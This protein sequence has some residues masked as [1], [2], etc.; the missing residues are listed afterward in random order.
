MFFVTL[1]NNGYRDITENLILSTYSIS[2]EWSQQFH[3][4]CLDEESF[5]YFTEKY[6]KNPVSKLYNHDSDQIKEWVKYYPMQSTNTVGKQSWSNFTFYK[7]ILI[8]EELKK[9]HNIV[10][11]DGDIVILRNFIQYI[12]QMIDMVPSAELIIQNDNQTVN[13]Q[14]MCTGFFWMKSNQN[15]ITATDYSKIN[16]DTFAN[17]QQYMRSKANVIKHLYLDLD[18]FPNGKYFRT[19]CNRNNFLPK[20]PYLIHFNYDVHK[21]KITRMKKYN[22]WFHDRDNLIMTVAEWQTYISSTSLSGDGGDGDDGGDGGVL[23]NRD[24]IINASSNDKCDSFMWN[25]IGVQ[26]DYLKFLKDN[27]FQMNNSFFSKGNNKELL[28]LVAFATST[29]RDRRKN[30]PVNRQ[31]IMQTLN[32]INAAISGCTTD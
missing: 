16:K 23:N 29:D 15:T 2:P 4:Y 6:P 11:L 24:I 13:E 20:N 30:H 17:D 19:H 25:P 31:S 9:G 10:F 8:H 1:T 26:H 7:I 14:N 5:D 3:I 12:Q 28:C 21:D 27:D 22:Y 18:H 32:K